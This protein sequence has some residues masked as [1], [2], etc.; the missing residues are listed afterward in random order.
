M[1]GVKYSTELTQERLARIAAIERC[2][3]NVIT[4]AVRDFKRGSKP[5]PGALS[6]VPS[7]LA[8]VVEKRK[9]ATS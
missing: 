5:E 9:H 1:R 4:A 3:R 7:K 2:Y 8:P 6:F